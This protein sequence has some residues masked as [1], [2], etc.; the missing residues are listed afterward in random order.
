M[1]KKDWTDERIAR[2]KKYVEASRYYHVFIHDF[3]VYGID[4]R[5]PEHGDAG[6]PSYYTDPSHEEG[7]AEPNELEKTSP[8]DFL[9]V[10][11]QPINWK[12]NDPP[13]LE[14]E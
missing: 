9:V 4:P 6:W 3:R 8:D 1:A 14:G 2:L 13:E 12:A 7:L 10:S 5:M 11:L